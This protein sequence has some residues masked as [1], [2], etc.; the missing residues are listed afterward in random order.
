MNR[1]LIAA[2]SFLLTVVLAVASACQRETVAQP[3]ESTRPANEVWVTQKQIRE[4]GIATAD[5]GNRPVGNSLV[6]TGRIT[7]SDTRVGHVFSPVTGRVTNCLVPLGQSVRRG[8]PLAI[9]E[10]PDLGTAVSDLEK[11]EADLVA[12]QREL[13]RQKELFDGHAAAQRDYEAA[14]SN[15]RKAKAE[16]ERAAQKSSLLLTGNHVTN[17]EYIV[18]APID[19][20]VVV[21]NVSLGM[22]VQGQYTGGNAA[23]LFTIGNLDPV[24]VLADVFELDLPRVYIGSPVLVNF[25]SYPG[26]QFAGKIDWISGVLDPATRTAKVRCTIAN[27]DHR[28][29]PEMFATV[30]IDTDGQEKLAVPRTSVIR[31]GDQL[32]AFVDKGL[33]RDGSERFE[34]R[35]VSVDDAEAGGDYVPVS[36]GLQP[37]EKVVIS[38]AI[39]LAGAAS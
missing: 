5:V 7:F 35:I 15:Y 8:T 20:D 23:E 16:R 28:L 26:R 9:I 4:A 1:T 33:S 24:W 37:G 29:R 39:I 2:S 38:G 21:R 34:R 12:A 36:R 18:R 25:V 13:E 31:L 22:E 27:A 14:E 3:V 30:S 32:V 10:S 19:G 17:H 6:T 11:A